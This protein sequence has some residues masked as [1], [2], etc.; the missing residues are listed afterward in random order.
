MTQTSYYQCVVSATVNSS[1]CSAAT[2]FVTVFVNDVTA[3]VIDADQTV[4]GLEDPT[5]L[6]MST[7]SIANGTLTYQW[8]SSTAGCSG[9]DE[10]WDWRDL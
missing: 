10:C 6:T 3:A 1:T 4:C 7:P 5:I 9:M 2:N 8:Q